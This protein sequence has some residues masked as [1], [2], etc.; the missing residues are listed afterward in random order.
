MQQSVEL[1][2]LLPND[3]L[4]RYV[5]SKRR[6]ARALNK[7]EIAH[8]LFVEAVERDNLSVD[9]LGFAP[10]LEM[11]EIADASAAARGKPFF[12]WVIVSVQRASNMGRKVM[13]V[14]LLNNPFHAEISLNLPTGAE[15]KDVATQHALD[16]AMH[17]TYQPRP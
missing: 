5:L 14:P 15:R 13:P 10:D 6:A 8:D 9:R 12:G 2:P 3:P 17:A 1:R 16:L 7:G 4:G 11:A